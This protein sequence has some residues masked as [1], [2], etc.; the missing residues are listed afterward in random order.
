[1]HRR[2][3]EIALRALQRKDVEVLLHT[4]A[5]QVQGHTVS[6][7]DGSTIESA[8]VVWSAGVQAS[9]FAASLPVPH[10]KGGAID[11]ESYLRVREHPG[12][13]AVG[14]NARLVDARN[15][16]GVPQLA[17]SAIQMGACAGDNVVAAIRGR[18]L[19]PFVYRS[20]GNSVSLGRRE[21]V[22]EVG[23]AVVG[24]LLGWATWRAVHLTKI[25]SLPDLLGV[26][27]DWSMDYAAREDTA[28]L[29]LV[30]APER[31]HA[32]ASPGV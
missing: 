9:E 14:D 11:V 10:A 30:H 1:M 16:E 26:A 2:M 7:G 29:E 5:Q 20:I 22:T 23:P 3:G 24:G 32:A 19:T 18:V 31:E 28:D 12:L 8:L 21:G 6:L 17:Q 4:R 15:P 13:Y 27:L 25:T